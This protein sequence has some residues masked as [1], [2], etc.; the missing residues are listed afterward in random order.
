MKLLT[1][2]VVVLICNQL[3]IGQ[4]KN[5]TELRIQHA[6]L[7]LVTQS[8]LKTLPEQTKRIRFYRETDGSKQSYE[9]KFKYKKYWYSVEFDSLGKLD[10]IEVNIKKRELEL[11]IE[12]A[13]NN[14]LNQNTEKFDIIKIQEQYLYDTKQTE[15]E[16][17]TFILKNRAEILSNYEIIIAIK[18]E[19]SW[20]LKEFTFDSEGRVLNTRNLQQDSYEYINY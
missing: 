8:I 10:D 7:P 1:L 6:D 17:L 2:I 11:P 3:T 13:I 14:Y 19:K 16:F 18:S 20:T 12:T 4:T 5:E 15:V 9:S